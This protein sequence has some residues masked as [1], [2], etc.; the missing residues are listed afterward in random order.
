MAVRDGRSCATCLEIR[1]IRAEN[2]LNR[3]CWPDFIWSFS[4]NSLHSTK[5]LNT[6]VM[7]ILING[8]LIFL[9]W[10]IFCRYWYVCKIK[11]HCDESPPPV[12]MVDQSTRAM[13]LGLYQD[14][15][16]VFGGYEQL[17]FEGNAVVP[18]LSA[19]NELF[20]DSLAGWLALHPDQ[21]LV[22][23]GAYRASEEGMTSGFLENLGLARAAS[24]RQLLVDR[25]VAENR[26]GLDFVK[27]ET[28]ELIPPVRFT[29]RQ[30]MA[31]AEGAAEGETAQSGSGGDAFTFSNMN[32][33]GANFDQNSDVFRPNATFE[34]YADSLKTY[35]TL[36]PDQ[37]LTITGHTDAL[38]SDAYNLELGRR[39]ALAVRNYLEGRGVKTKFTISS[40]GERE[41]VATNDTEEGRA[42]NRRV[43]LKIN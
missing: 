28:E 6:A 24:I 19:S 3:R 37:S 8:F 32:F 15:Q 36:H 5:Y 34:A 43:N 30:A 13:D 40:A 14:G 16:L 20:L 23:T 7:R 41:P 35:F 26:I 25:G 31:A 17:A 42:K 27:S 29:V 9:L 38:S 18:V 1:R 22:L 4:L 33:S 10:A 21:G 12:E 39:R 11:H 2:K